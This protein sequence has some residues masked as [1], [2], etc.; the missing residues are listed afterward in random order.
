MMA[1][2]GRFSNE[3]HARCVLSADLMRELPSPNCVVEISS[4]SCGASY[5]CSPWVDACSSD[6]DIV[7]VD[8]FVSA[9]LC[10]DACSARDVEL[11]H[12]GTAAQASSVVLRV[13]GGQSAAL[14][15]GC[16]VIVRKRIRTSLRG[17]AIRPGC[18]VTFPA[19][20]KLQFFVVSTSPQSLVF[21]GEHTRFTF[22]TENKAE[23]G[24]AL[25][26]TAPIAARG[27]NAQWESIR[28]MLLMPPEAFPSHM[29][30]PSGCLLYGPP[31]VGKTHMVRCLV[32]D[33]SAQMP[34]QLIIVDSSSVYNA[35]SLGDG[36][37]Y[38]R[39]A[40]SAARE[41]TESFD[42]TCVL[43]CDELDAL[44][45]ARA[46][47]AAHESRI[48]GQ[49]LTLMDGNK[50][51]ESN[52]RTQ[53]GRLLVCAA[54]N[55]VND[56]DPA[57]RRPGRFEFEIRV[58]P[59][60]S[61][62]RA[63]LIREVLGAGGS[64]KVDVALIA[65]KC[66]GYVAADIV[67]LV[68]E[69]KIAASKR[70][71]T[72]VST[73]DFVAA[74]EKVVASAVRSTRIAIDR[75]DWSSVG[76][77]QEVKRQLKQLIEWPRRYKSKFEEFGIKSPRGALLYG[78]PGCSKT[79]LVRIAATCSNHTF[80]T[81]S[82]ADVFSP[83]LGHAERTIREAFAKAR[84]ALPAIVFLDEIDATVCR[85]SSK[86]N[87]SGGDAMQERV[88][89]TL[90]NE[91]DGIDTADG[92]LCI[93]ATN[94]PEMIDD[95][96]MRP[97]RFER[98]LYCPPPDENARLEI[99]NVHTRSTSLSGVDLKSIARR[100]SRYTG[101]EL[102]ALCMEAAVNALRSGSDACSVSQSHFEA[103]LEASKPALS[104]TDIRAYEA[105]EASR[106]RIE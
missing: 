28:A 36:E 29:P 5:I 17:I 92:L 90:L 61:H 64:A 30:L 52:S 14:P 79:S 98:L 82:M 9:P 19:G 68:R 41:F 3:G 31:G 76:G 62:E 24:F 16:P 20:V 86:A 48:V 26:V 73:Q 97:G 69:A 45:P 6:A 11:R 88:L 12:L 37:L 15:K 39:N 103:A 71:A 43:F 50:T 34:T 95:A 89:S 60:D 93:G 27:R 8:T 54:T 33:L 47:S 99:L 78:P 106:K 81:L 104:E 21:C 2:D 25:A 65:E 102:E 38:L 77:M 55:R 91:M 32:Q 67:A 85:R 10:D 72:A 75:R 1:T 22:E 74:S 58:G 66:T 105:F 42:G 83:F 63:I 101:A 51:K 13:S 40:F 35:R 59:P 80:I 57:L 70:Q 56:I 49:L 7:S 23:R 46:N 94:R 96:L 53:R 100:T 87:G 4:Q 84:A 44:C 18:T